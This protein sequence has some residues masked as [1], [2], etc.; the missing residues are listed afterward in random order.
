MEVM[1]D[2]L[3]SCGLGEPVGVSRGVND[4]VLRAEFPVGNCFGEVS[5]LGDIGLLPA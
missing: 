5:G 2:P 1:D 3:F 4:A